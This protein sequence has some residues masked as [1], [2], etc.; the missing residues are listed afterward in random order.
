MAAAMTP[1]VGGADPGRRDHRSPVFELDV[2]ALLAQGRG[3]E[4]RQP[5][6]A[7]DREHADGA[8]LNLRRELSQTR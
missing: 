8:G 1:P 5:F 2:H 4:A 7:G 6:G 3:V